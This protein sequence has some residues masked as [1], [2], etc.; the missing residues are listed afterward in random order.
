M[1]TFVNMFARLAFVCLAMELVCGDSSG[2]SSNTCPLCDISTCENETV[3]QESCPGVKLVND[4][5]ACCKQCGRVFGESCGGA[6]GYLGK[7][8]PNLKCTVEP[9]AYLNGANVSGNCTSEFTY[10]YAASRGT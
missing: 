10:I 7:C 9:S 2:G 1:R 6:Y 3:V 8:E 4:P 5:C